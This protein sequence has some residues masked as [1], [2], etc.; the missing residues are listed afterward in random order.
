MN[1][2]STTAKRPHDQAVGFNCPKCKFFIA[3][4][5]KSLL[6]QPSHRCPGCLTDFVMNQENSKTALEV[7]QKLDVVVSNL[8]ASKKFNG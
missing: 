3:V 2:Q 8:E 4:T 5:L 7:I 6:T 1:T